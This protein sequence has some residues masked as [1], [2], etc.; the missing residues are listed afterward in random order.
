[1]SSSLSSLW[2]C[3][4]RVRLSD[5]RLSNVDAFVLG[6]D[7]YGLE[8]LSFALKHMRWNIAWRMRVHKLVR[9]VLERLKVE[10]HRLFHSA[11]LFVLQRRLFEFSEDFVVT[12]LVVHVQDVAGPKT[13]VLGARL[14]KLLVI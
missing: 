5:L 8:F 11:H 7:R 3:F 2:G 14:S 6:L 10:L 13:L 12:V 1:M 9:V 4:K